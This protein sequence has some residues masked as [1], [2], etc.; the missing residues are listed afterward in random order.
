MSGYRLHSVA[1]AFTLAGRGSAAP[2]RRQ[3]LQTQMI[4][5]HEFS[6]NTA[7]RVHSYFVLFSGL[8]RSVRY[9]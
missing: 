1:P 8:G 3:Q 6:L 4:A 7:A 5:E 9:N 2:R